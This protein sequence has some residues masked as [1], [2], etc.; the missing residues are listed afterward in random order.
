LIACFGQ[1]YLYFDKTS[2]GIGRQ[3]FVFRSKRRQLDHTSAI[4]IIRSNPYEG[5]SIQTAK[6]KYVFNRNLTKPELEWLV[7]EIKD[8][9]NQ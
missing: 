1:N 5:I 3:L 9:L 2:F 8:W 7:Q 4:K 6:Q